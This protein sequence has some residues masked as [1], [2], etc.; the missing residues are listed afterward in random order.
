MYMIYLVIQTYHLFFN[1]CLLLY[2]K[3][4]LSFFLSIFF[5]PFCSH[6]LVQF[7]SINFVENDCAGNHNHDLSFYIEISL[8][9]EHHK[10]R[11][12]YYQII[13]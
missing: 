3:N 7:P 8:V 9:F 6:F 5:P 2:F 12:H 13:Q 1:Y 11:Y 10:H 4:F